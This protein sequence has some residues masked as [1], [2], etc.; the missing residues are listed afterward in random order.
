MAAGGLYAPATGRIKQILIRV[1]LSWSNVSKRAQPYLARFMQSA[2]AGGRIARK[3][4]KGEG[5]KLSQE[6]S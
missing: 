2:G 3:A 4:G 6:C 5:R 1:R